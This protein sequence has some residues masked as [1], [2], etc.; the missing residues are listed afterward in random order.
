[1]N[2]LPIGLRLFLHGLIH[3]TVGYS[4]GQADWD[5]K[6]NSRHKTLDG[7]KCRSRPGM[8]PGEPV[9]ALQSAVRTRLR[10]RIIL[11]Q[12]TGCIFLLETVLE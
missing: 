6:K 3:Y 9:V 11:R 4:A 5:E 2:S 1:M 8:V 7:Y 10:L 12:V